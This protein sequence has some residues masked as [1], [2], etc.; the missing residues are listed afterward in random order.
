MKK[1][2]YRPVVILT[3]FVVFLTTMALADSID[4]LHKFIL[5]PTVRVR[6]DNSVG[7]GVIFT[8]KQ[9]TGRYD[10]Y[11]LTNHHVVDS[12][13]QI[14]EE[15]DSLEKKSIK[16][17]KR[18][19]IEV[20]IFKYLNMSTATG[21]LLVLTDIVEWNKD[22]DLALLKMRSDE[23]VES[24]KLL[25]KDKVDKLRIFDPVYVCGSGLGRSPFPTAGQIASLSDE[26]DNLPYWMLNAPSVFGNSGG[27][28]FLQATQ[29]YIGIPSRIAV[30]WAVWAPN[31]VYHMSYIIPISRIYKWLEETGW[32][33][34]YDPKAIKH[35]DW[36]KEKKEKGKEK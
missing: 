32:A 6:A 18:A 15:W 3:L 33:E 14:N 11:I 35:E 21:T 20:E 10:T 8:C 27:G 22:H 31:A 1:I 9:C 26:I 34:L 16:K 19:T 4:D 2:R 29:E 36:L 5:Y 30:T 13:I 23:K 12:A 7:S 28:A 25:P 24:V 17:E